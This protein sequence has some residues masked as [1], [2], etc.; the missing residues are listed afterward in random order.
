MRRLCRGAR[1]LRACGTIPLRKSRFDISDDCGARGR[2]S[3]EHV[4]AHGSR[5]PLTA[6]CAASSRDASRVDGG[7]RRT[8]SHRCS[9][10]HKFDVVLSERRGSGAARMAA[11]QPPHARGGPHQR[12]SRLFEGRGE[13]CVGAL[14]D[15]RA[16]VRSLP[17][18]ARG[19]RSVHA[20]AEHAGDVCCF[21]TGRHGTPASR[22]RAAAATVAWLLARRVGHGRESGGDRAPRAP[23]WTEIAED[24]G[25]SA[26]R[27]STLL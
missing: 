2:E 5:Q 9:R 13:G 27:A 1:R 24:G 18:V 8:R 6:A 7:T 14:D 26:G 10:P 19:A 11:R 4:S 15:R 22:Q 25:F 12:P 16:G 20:A 21:S 17:G 23:A 3:R